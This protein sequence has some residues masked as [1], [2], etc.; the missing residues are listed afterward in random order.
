M[1]GQEDHPCI[2]AYLPGQCQ[3]GAASH[4]ILPLPGVESCG[5]VSD[6]VLLMSGSCQ[7]S[8]VLVVLP[9]AESADLGA[10]RN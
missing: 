10:G 3:Q 4:F 5:L 7:A 8:S 6:A 1:Q 9:L 2:S